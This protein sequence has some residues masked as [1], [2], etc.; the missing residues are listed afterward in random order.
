MAEN[1]T[2]F[3]KK[4]FTLC[5]QIAAYICCC[6]CCMR[7]PKIANSESPPHNNSTDLSPQLRI[8][9][10]SDDESQ[11]STAENLQVSEPVPLHR[12]MTICD[13]AILTE[14]SENNSPNE[15]KSSP[16][17]D[18]GEAR[19]FTF[20]TFFKTTTEITTQLQPEYM[21]D[22]FKLSSPIVALNPQNTAPIPKSDSLNSN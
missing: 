4:F 9:P 19:R 11:N 21:I 8:S 14:G 12:S 5:A 20:F 1:P 18:S 10:K 16:L 7:T 13:L 15:C 2:K 17:I 22:S 3:V 6:G